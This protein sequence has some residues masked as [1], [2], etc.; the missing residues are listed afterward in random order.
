MRL[1]CQTV[2]AADTHK[3]THTHADNELSAIVVA[4][5]VGD[6]RDCSALPFIVTGLITR[7]APASNAAPRRG[8]QSGTNSAN[9][10]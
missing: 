5:V 4:V 7:L 2:A 8:E 6:E 1:V 9:S 3:H 10:L